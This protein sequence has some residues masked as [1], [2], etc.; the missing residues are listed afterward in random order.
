MVNIW[1]NEDGRLADRSV[2]DLA[3]RGVELAILRNEAGRR[4]RGSRLDSDHLTNIERTESCQEFYS[5]SM[6]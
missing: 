2:G 1:G 4:K 3:D 6:S 5:Y